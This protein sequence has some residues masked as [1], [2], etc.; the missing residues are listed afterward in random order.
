LLAVPVGGQI[1]Q[2]INA[3]YLEREGF[4]QQAEHLD[5]PAIERFMAALPACEARL[6]TY[7]QDGNTVLFAALEEQLKR[8]AET[9]D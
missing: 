9:I 3:R 8:A 6:A 7:R 2:V 1:E 5:G 4:G